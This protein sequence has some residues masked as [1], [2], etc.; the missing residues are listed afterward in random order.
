MTD[1]AIR[2]TPAGWYED[3]ADPAR[4]RWWNGVAWTEHTN[5]KPGLE[6]AVA[7][8]VEETTASGAGVTP[9][10]AVATEPEPD[11]PLTRREAI[12]AEG[13]RQAPDARRSATGTV[14]LIALLPVIAFAIGI[15]ALYVFAYVAPS[16]WVALAALLPLLLGLLWAISD[17]R[18]LAARGF[19]APS[20]LWA[21]LTPFGYLI[22]RRIRVPGAGPL[23]LFAVTTVVAVAAPLLFWTSGASAVVTVPV[24]VQHAVQTQLVETGRIGSVSCPPLIGSLR[25]G[26]LFTCDATTRSGGPTEVWVSIDSSDGTFSIAPA[27]RP[28]SS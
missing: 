18:Q 26:T 17:R 4:V 9:G 6:A 25:P 22:A 19:P 11:R 7:A 8:P 2:V 28:G 1:Q 23:V 5:A 16:S 24:R 14:W 20:A 3:P 12:A 21:L 13:G 15:G 10:A 27:I